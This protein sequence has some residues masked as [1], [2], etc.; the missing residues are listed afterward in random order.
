MLFATKLLQNAKIL[1]DVIYEATV[2]MGSTISNMIAD[3]LKKILDHLTKPAMA[4]LLEIKLAV[5]QMYAGIETAPDRQVSF[6]I[7]IFTYDSLFTVL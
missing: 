1:E 6:D 5:K 7:S 4:K 2:R 3:D